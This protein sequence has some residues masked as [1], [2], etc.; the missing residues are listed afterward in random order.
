MGKVDV[1][2]LGVN[3]EIEQEMLVRSVVTGFK[4]ID[5]EC[6]VIQFD[7]GKDLYL[8]LDTSEIELIRTVIL[9]E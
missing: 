7:G 9:P 3:E 6:Y 8:H 2:H 1:Q 4:Q 5:P